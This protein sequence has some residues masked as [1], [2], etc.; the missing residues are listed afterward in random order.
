MPTRGTSA[1]NFYQ[2]QEEPSSANH[3]ASC[4]AGLRLGVAA[5]EALE[6]PAGSNEAH[7]TDILEGAG[8]EVSARSRRNG[9]L[10]WLFLGWGG[11]DCDISPGVLRDSWPV[12]SEDHGSP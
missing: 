11:I 4:V 12:A 7:G 1:R 10:D 9:K 2:G 8:G 5:E 3:L 6:G